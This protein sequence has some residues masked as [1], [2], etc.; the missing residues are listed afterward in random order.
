MV[1]Q[2]SAAELQQHLSAARM[3]QDPTAPGPM[4]KQPGH[5]WQPLKILTTLDLPWGRIYTANSKEHA[6]WKL[7]AF[8]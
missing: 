8:D 6:K 7:I 3:A 2:K 4:Q 5:L 1:H